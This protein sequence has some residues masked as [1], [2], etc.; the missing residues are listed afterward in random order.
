MNQ[1]D[2]SQATM[3]GENA[4]PPPNAAYSETVAPQ[5][6]SRRSAR[7]LVIG[8]LLALV[9]FVSLLVVLSVFL[10]QKI[11]ELTDSRLAEAEA[12][13]DRAAPASYDIDLEI[14]GAR[15]GQVQVKVR[16]SAVSEMTRE[17]RTP[18]ERTW[19]TWSVPGLFETLE[20]ELEMAQDPVHEMN[21]TSGM[22]VWLR[23]DFD[24]Q[25]GYPHVYHRLVT[26]GGPEVYWR[27]TRF[28]PK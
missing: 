14:R 15:P 20:R 24:P 25:Y 16:D 9:G 23:C 17:G 13:W 12:L 28:E 8:L 19:H 26:G 10:G 5:S 2:L 21:A 27:V 7:V 22:E 11:P 18:P 6:D 3:S 4:N 1:H